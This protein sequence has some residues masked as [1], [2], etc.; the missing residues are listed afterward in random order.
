MKTNLNLMRANFASK[1]HLPLPK[2][3]G[4]VD[5][6]LRGFICSCVQFSIC[7]FVVFFI[8]AMLEDFSGMELVSGFLTTGW[9]QKDGCCEE[10]CTYMYNHSQPSG[11]AALTESHRI[12]VCFNCSINNCYLTCL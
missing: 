4:E 3:G 5:A 12:S 6:K 2:T 8:H 1:F 11:S 7:F 10:G 9:F